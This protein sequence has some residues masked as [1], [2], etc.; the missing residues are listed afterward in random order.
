MTPS[1]LILGASIKQQ[2]WSAQNFECQWMDW[3]FL[4]LVVLSHNSKLPR[5][6]SLGGRS[7][8]AINTIYFCYRVDSLLIC[9]IYQS[10]E[11][12]PSAFWD[13]IYNGLICAA[14]NGASNFAPSNE[15]WF[16]S[17]NKTDPSL[18]TKHCISSQKVSTG[19]TVMNDPV[20]L[21]PSNA[22]KI[23][24]DSANWFFAYFH[25]LILTL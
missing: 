9:K 15:G 16:P 17:K 21:S 19:S 18:I 3:H 2:S 25:L 23:W 4:I 11:P 7:D 24:R 5:S 10:I 20:T 14:I 13:Q 22:T 12:Q 6:A 8:G 1:T